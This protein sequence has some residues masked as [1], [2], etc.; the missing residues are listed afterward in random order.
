MVSWSRERTRR[1]LRC[2]A[3][4][5]VPTGR[6]KCLLAAHTA[7]DARSGG[8]SP[9]PSVRM[10]HRREP[11]A[12]SSLAVGLFP[13][14]PHERGSP[15]RASTAAGDR[16]RRGSEARVRRGYRGEQEDGRNAMRSSFT[17][18]S[19]AFSIHGA[20]SNVHGS[21]QHKNVFQRR[22]QGRLS[23]PNWQTT[24]DAVVARNG[25]RKLDSA[26]SEILHGIQAANLRLA[27]SKYTSSGVR[28]S[29]AL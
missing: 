9:R 22:V 19:D 4:A 17:L 14:Y 7:T 15:P 18:I 27:W 6:S 12:C 24:M 16:L 1:P 23:D 10:N 13:R 29:S 5:L 26:V 20:T 3:H 28:R 8:N 25:P 2:I 21:R 11:P